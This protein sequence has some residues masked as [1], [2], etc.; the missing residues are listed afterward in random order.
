M[1]AGEAF[2]RAWYAEVW[3]GRDAKA[4]HR[5]GDERFIFH[6]VGPDGGD[7]VGVAAFL[8]FQAHILGAFPDIAISLDQVIEQGPLVAHR[9]SATMTHKGEWMGRP[10]T[11]KRLVLT[12]MGFARTG[13][14]GKPLEAWD[15]WDRYGLL[16]QIDGAG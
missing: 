13:D 4:A 11:G 7:V 3:N 6:N 1:G 15:E 5:L 12:G 16:Q 2:M 9:W 14:D 8:E 10:P